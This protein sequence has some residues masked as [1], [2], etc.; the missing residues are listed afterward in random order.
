MSFITHTAINSLFFVALF[1]M[2]FLSRKTIKDSLKEKY[3]SN[4]DVFNSQ[5]FNLSV[6][7]SATLFCVLWFIKLNL[8]M[9]M[10]IVLVNFFPYRLLSKEEKGKV[11]RRF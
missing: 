10:L 9:T 7:T 2:V 8:A 4:Y 3:D 6:S 11:F 1:N 5:Y